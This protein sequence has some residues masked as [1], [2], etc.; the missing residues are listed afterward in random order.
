MNLS[1]GYTFL[2]TTS[3]FGYDNIVELLLNRGAD[4][5][6][7]NKDHNNALRSAI[8]G[9][10]FDCTKLLVDK[11]VF[12]KKA[13]IIASKIG[14]NDIIVLLHNNGYDINEVIDENDIYNSTALIMAC[15]KK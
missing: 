4:V 15:A 3:Y 13:L 14:N 11:K 2:M 6:I 9:N 8:I 12:N 5:T 7:I 1:M 10:S